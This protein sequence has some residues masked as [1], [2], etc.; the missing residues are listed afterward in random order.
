MHA[1][2]PGAVRLSR[3]RALATGLAAVSAAAASLN[4]TAL[5]SED[6]PAAA[7]PYGPFQMGIQSYS[8]RNFKV[9][10]ALAMTQELGLHVWESYPAHIPAEAATAAASKQKT[11]A[12]GVTVNGFGV[13]AFSADH[14]ANRKFFEFGKALGVGYFSADPDPRAFDSLDKLCEE[15]GIGVGIHNHGPGHRYAT[16]ESIQA[17]I[18]DHHPRIGCC[19]DTGHF[20]RSKIDPVA[21]VEAFD[22]RIFGVHLKDVKDAT[23]FTVLGEGD[24]RIADLLKA[25]AAR[26]YSYALALEYEEHPENPMA[27]IQQCL[28]ATRKA[29]AAR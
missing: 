17:A 12:A 21:A 4:W 2:D 20:L 1:F 8:L 27:E 6:P 3:R 25:L 7:G 24:L 28:A 18:K 15:Y 11:A 5:A 22:K 19:V 14:D 10:Q 23:T 16:I 29:V 13:I 26:K 9:D